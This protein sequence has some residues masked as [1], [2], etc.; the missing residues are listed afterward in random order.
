MPRLPSLTA[1][2]VVKALKNAGFLEDRQKGSHLV[3]IHPQSKMRTVVPVHPGKT[4]KKP[5]L[6]AIIADA[7]LNAETFIS[8]L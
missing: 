4:I 1:K 2:D 6:H 3:L 7:G 8:L 5:L